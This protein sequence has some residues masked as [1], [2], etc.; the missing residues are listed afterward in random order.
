MRSHKRHLIWNSQSGTITLFELI[1]VIAILGTLVGFL[2]PSFMGTRQD[3][4]IT[5]LAT[6]AQALKRA[7]ERY[8]IDVGV[9][10][11]ENSVTNRHDL[12]VNPYDSTSPLFSKWKGPYI[13]RPLQS[14]SVGGQTAVINS[15]NITF[16][17]SDLTNEDGASL[18]VFDLT[19]DE[20]HLYDMQYDPEQPPTG[21]P[22]DWWKTNG[23]ILWG[24]VVPPN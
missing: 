5:E 11:I 4:Q 16:N 13:D 12:I 17:G 22:A 9:W 8:Y 14:T 1:L 21:S 10:P 20:A 7:S 15:D 19:E 3:S 23:T 2:L 18:L 24:D 6:T